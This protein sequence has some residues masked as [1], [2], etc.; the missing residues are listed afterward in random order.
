MENFWSGFIT[1]LWLGILTSLSPCPLATNVA[2]I[3]YLSK[4]INHPGLVGISGLAYTLGRMTLYATLGVLLI[5]SILGV[6][7]A[8]GFLQKYMNKALG[9]VLILVALILMGVVKIRLP[10]FSVSHRFQTRLA[11]AGAAGAF[12]LGFLFALA[13]CPVSAALFFGSLIPLAL[14][15][16]AGTTLPLVYGLGTGLP[17]SL[18]AILT[19]V[20]IKSLGRFFEKISKVEFYMRGMTAAVFILVGIYYIATYILKR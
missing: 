8:A 1:A 10:D 17:V 20:G 15:H 11:D 7:E 13:F 6:P 5:H 19:A 3:S 12:A 9:P 18:F 2:S 4:K 14:H 16:P